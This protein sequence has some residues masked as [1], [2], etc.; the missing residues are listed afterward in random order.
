MEMIRSGC[1]INLLLNVLRRRE[2][3]W[4]DLETVM[5]PLPLFDE[6]TVEFAD[7]PGIELLCNHP[8]TPA[9]AENLICRAASAF[10]DAIGK[11][12]GLQFRLEKNIPV[13]AGMGGGSGNAAAALLAL[14]R[15]YGGVLSRD[16]VAATAARL[17]SDVPFFLESGPA[18]ALG[19]GEKV[20][21][22]PPFDIFED[23]C[24]VLVNPGFGVPTPWAYR[25]LRLDAEEGSSAPVS[26]ESFV[27]A[28]R[29]GD[30]EGAMRGLFN[31][32]ERL[33]FRK[34]P[35]LEIIRLELLRVGA[36]GAL[37]SGSGA[38]IFGIVRDK[39]QGEEVRQRFLKAFG[40][41]CWSCVL[42]LAGE[43]S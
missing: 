31:S 13:A 1:K 38:T 20:K 24:V 12:D 43:Q 7:R 8:K 5:Q 35:V 34:Y 29:V 30:W 11:S 15:L 16:A 23:A 18:I 2:D 3:G 17:G 21:R 40:D 9:G 25:N 6:L 19:R 32:L 42:N 39:E 37:M 22:L 33:V 28:L 27:R 41:Q 4:H 26:A 14:N 36:T 10:Q